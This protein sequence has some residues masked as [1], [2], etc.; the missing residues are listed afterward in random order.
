[1]PEDPI[2]G[3]GASP[4]I[5]K[6]LPPIVALLLLFG[7]GCVV[8]KSAYD[9]KSR[10]SDS[11][12]DALASL[13]REKTRLSEE[14]AALAGQV[15]AAKDNEA[16]LAA[17]VRERDERLARM[18]E[19]LGAARQTYEGSRITREQFINELLE[20]EKATGRR[21][22]ELAGR[23]EGDEKELARV[24]AENAELREKLS[25]LV[26]REEETRRDRDILS[27]RV[28]RHK[29]ERREAAARRDAA[30]ARLASE[31]E[32]ISPG[33][34]VARVG[35]ALR[36]VVPEKIA[37]KERGGKLTDAGVAIVAAVS[38]VVGE[39]PGAALLVVAG[40][41]NSAE[42]FRAAAASEGKIPEGRLL[43]HVR[44]KERSAELLLIAP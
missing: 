34:V 30:L 16:S 35:D 39:L 6:V 33:I 29:E 21:L 20:K 18:G 5:R 23:A 28:E 38:G 31:L 7:P 44:E 27:G 42:T 41:K 2:A 40:G 25:T 19:D 11:L 13:N 22:Q 26:P 9:L 43:S 8:T 15:S 10:E 36:I 1:V 37:L 24:R 32:R 14:N 12:R 3:R 17:Q 4:L